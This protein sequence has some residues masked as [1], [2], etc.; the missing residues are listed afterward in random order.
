MWPGMWK[1]SSPRND[2]LFVGAQSGMHIIDISNR[3]Q[4]E[5][6]STYRHA[7]NCDPVIV[8]GDVAYVTLRS[9]TECEGWENQLDVIDISNLRSPRLM[10][11]FP[12]HNP[13]GLSKDGDAL[14][15]CDGDD[16]LKVFDASELAVLDQQLLAHDRS[17]QAYDVIAYNGIAMLIGDDGLHQYDYS[18]LNN[19]RHLSTITVGIE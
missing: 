11:T 14:F 5:Q 12:M 13:H 1:R 16:G 6:L 2:E 18:D 4:P 9:G 17:I 7:T 10:H 15:I 19:I 8:D 3:N